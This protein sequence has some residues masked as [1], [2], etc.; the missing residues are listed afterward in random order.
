[1]SEPVNSKKRSQKR[2]HLLVISQV[3]VPDPAAVGQHLADVAEAMVARG[4]DVTVYTSARGYDDPSERYLLQEIRKGVDVRRFALSSFGKS[5]IAVRLAAQIL[6]LIQASARAMCARRFDCLLVSTSPPFAGFFGAILS[7]LRRKPLVWWVMDINPDQMVVAGKLSRSSLLVTIF[8]WMN[9]VTLRQATAVVTLDD[10]MADTLKRKYDASAKMHVIPPWSHNESRAGVQDDANRFRKAHGLEGRFVVMY[11]GNHAIQHPLDTLL[12]A[13]KQLE[14]DARFIFVFVGG[15]AGK[16][17]VERRI[18]EGA[19]NLLSLP[20]QPLEAISDCLAAADV[21]VV[22]MGNDMVGIVHP[23]K[24][25]GAL[26]TGRPVLGF[27]PPLS[28]VASLLYA[29]DRGWVVAHGEVQQ[30]TTVLR[31]AL[32]EARNPNTE[33]FSGGR[34]DAPSCRKSRQ[35]LAVLCDTIENATKTALPFAHF[36][37][38]P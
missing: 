1:M 20:Y 16:A 3:Y 29:S 12:D 19:G 25:Y 33:I 15:G 8:D 27:A 21:H 32:G 14:C 9:R 28:H 35:L 10:Y 37:R 24:I 34:S 5:S 4:W 13:A 31:N 30:T 18:R 2:P 36:S 17:E 23:C 26:A 22:S 7:L 6:F 38:R 11:A